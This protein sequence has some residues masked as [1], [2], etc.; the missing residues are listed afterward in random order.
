MQIKSEAQRR[1]LM[2]NK[3]EVLK[4]MEAET[5]KDQKLPEKSGEPRPKNNQQVRWL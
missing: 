4:K 3:P 2:E 1:W 5:P